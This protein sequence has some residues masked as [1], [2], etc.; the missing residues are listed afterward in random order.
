ML[1]VGDALL[2][3]GARWLD[4]DSEMVVGL[5]EETKQLHGV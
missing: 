1:V 4:H 5:A 2:I 3:L